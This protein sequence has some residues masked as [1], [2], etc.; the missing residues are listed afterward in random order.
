MNLRAPRSLEAQRLAKR[1]VAL[2]L[3]DVAELAEFARLF[4][5]V[6]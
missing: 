3:D 4:G 5:S 6:C 2:V 1:L